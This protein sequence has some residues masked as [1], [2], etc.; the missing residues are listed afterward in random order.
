MG[1]KRGL[2]CICFLLLLEAEGFYIRRTFL[3]GGLLPMG[4][5]EEYAY[6]LPP[7][8][9]NSYPGWMEQK[10]RELSNDLGDMNG[11][12]ELSKHSIL[13]NWT[14]NLAKRMSLDT[15]GYYPN[16][17]I[18]EL[19]AGKAGASCGPLALILD[20][21]SSVNGVETRRIFVTRGQLFD[22][23]DV[24]V[25]VEMWSDKLQKW[26]VNSPM[27]NCFF[28]KSNDKAARLNALEIHKISKDC[29]NDSFSAR[30]CI[31]AVQDLDRTYPTLQS[32]Y[33]DPLLLYNH[34]FV[35][36]LRRNA[37]HKELP[38]R[39]F[40]RLLNRYYPRDRILYV[41]P[42]GA[43]VPLPVMFTIGLDYTLTWIIPFLI[44]LLGFLIPAVKSQVKVKNCSERRYAA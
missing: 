1:I 30:D 40:S 20:A 26:Y 44:L 37:Y 16:E 12:D 23:A 3:P 27:F 36:N 13:R 17:M 15:Q 39:A 4:I 42:K 10:I 7:S 19:R 28:V 5:I 25:T 33:I 8:T 22:R 11:L 9:K 18:E 31:K 14:R 43:A 41:R 24:H 34:V 35:I 32:Y 6:N 2:V 29:E 38:N 21:I